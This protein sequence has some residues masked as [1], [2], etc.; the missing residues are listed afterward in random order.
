MRPEVTI[1]PM[2]ADDISAADDAAWT[3]LREQIPAEF[4]EQAE[5]RGRTGVARIR[6]EH[7]LRTDPG[8]CHVAEVEGAVAGVALA[9]ARDGLWGLSLF[10]VHPDHQGRGIGRGLLQRALDYGAGCDRGV[11][12]SSQDSRALRR[13]AK[14]GFALRP[15][16]SAT[17]PVNASR[18]PDRLA[19]R[20]GDPEADAATIEAASRHVRGASYARDVPAMIAAGCVLLVHEG[21]GFACARDG[22]PM[23]LAALDDE[24]AT[25]LL[26]ACLAAGRP[27]ESVHVD[28]LTAEQQWAVAPVL[29]AGLSLACDGPVFTRGALGRMAPSIPSG[30]Y[31]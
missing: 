15:C 8:G 1:R 22:S 17:G 26:W 30:A 18:I 24:A 5:A 13:Y 20:T 21:R 12:L 28:F 10:A 31:L 2:V 25:D 6:F 27:G 14:A 16:F 11:I 3:A 19:S 29:E 4:V 23:L 9:L 7:L